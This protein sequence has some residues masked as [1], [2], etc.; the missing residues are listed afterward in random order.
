MPLYEF[1]CESCN[2]KFESTEP[3]GT[4]EV[5]CE[6][7]GKKAVLQLSFNIS[8]TIQGNNDASTTPK[9]KR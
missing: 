3:I 9:R 6:L 8:Y 5:P 1:L 4:K 2:H 7:C